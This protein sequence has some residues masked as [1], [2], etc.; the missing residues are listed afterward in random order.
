MRYITRTIWILSAVSLFTDMASELLYPVMPLYLKSIG[1]SVLIIGILEGIA[2]AAAGLSKGYFGRWSDQSG[3][4][5]PFV[6]VGYSLSAIAKPLLALFN[7]PVW[8]MTMRTLDR[9]GKGIRTGARDAMLSGEATPQTKATVFGFHRAM[10]TL[11]AV[12][13]PALGLVYL[14]FNPGD[15]KPLFFYALIPGILAIAATRLLREKAASPQPTPISFFS[16]LNYWK[17]SPKA[18]RRIVIGLLLFALVNSSDI[19]LL[20]QAKQRGLDEVDVIAIYIFYNLVYAVFSFPMGLLADRIGLKAIFITGLLLFAAVYAGLSVAESEV[21]FII[22]FFLYG[23]YAASTEGISKAW[24]TNVVDPKD[25]GTAV[26]TYSAF[27]S[28]CL[29]LASMWTGLIWY[30]LGAAYAFC[31]SAFI[32]SMAALYFAIW[33]FNDNHN[34]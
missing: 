11:G 4:R 8:I 13:G 9:L 27:Q 28:I 7:W 10:D 6:Q 29:M 33:P 25:T 12:L 16:F 14:Y 26:G 30:T 1:F 19:F 18:Y 17:Q 15:Y 34:Q 3:K 21:L 31:I 22:L 24:L 2:E 5:L 23:L 32:T 20:L